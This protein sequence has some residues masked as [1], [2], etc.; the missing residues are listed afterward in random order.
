MVEREKERL[1]KKNKKNRVQAA[2][3]FCQ[4][5]FFHSEPLKPLESSQPLVRVCASLSFTSVCLSQA[6][7]AVEGGWGSERRE[8]MWLV[9]LPGVVPYDTGN[10][11][12][13]GARRKWCR[14]VNVCVFTLVI[15]HIFNFP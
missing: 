1:G 10:N 4:P 9:G 12:S 7:E 15:R 8:K 13:N 6:G 2:V 3:R 11:I 5:F 14:C